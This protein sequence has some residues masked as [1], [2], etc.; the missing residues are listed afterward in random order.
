MTAAMEQL[1]KQPAE[2]TGPNSYRR[3]GEA[4]GHCTDR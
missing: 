4:V 2:P 1:H 3:R